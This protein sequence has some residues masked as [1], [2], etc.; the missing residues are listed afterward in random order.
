MTHGQCVWLCSTHGSE[1]FLKR[2]S[3]HEFADRLAATWSAAGVLTVRRKAALDAHVRSI[4]QA[5]ISGDKPG[6][7]SWPLLRREAERR[8]AAGEPPAQVIGQLREN[9]AD[10][11]AMVPSARTMRRWFTQAR[12][13]ETPSPPRSGRSVTSRVSGS[14]WR[15]FVNLILTGFAYPL[16]GRP[17]NTPRGP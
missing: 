3:G 13:L 9:Y 1:V 16:S 12:W 2:R 15:P 17:H 11:P 4:Q 14:E 7:Y 10:G 8:F 5:A 6:S